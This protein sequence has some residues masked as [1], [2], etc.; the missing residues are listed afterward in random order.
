M[1]NDL[2]SLFCFS[3]GFA[4][5]V[6]NQVPTSFYNYISHLFWGNDTMF[7]RWQK[8]PWVNWCMVRALDTGR[9]VLV[10]N[11]FPFFFFFVLD[12][13]GEGCKSND[14]GVVSKFKQKVLGDGHIDKY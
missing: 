8:L 13:K 10:H 7:T 11:S 12:K 2:F 6:D 5:C 1:D 9:M 3:F 4:L 14:I